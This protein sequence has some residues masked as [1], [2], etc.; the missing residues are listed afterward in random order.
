LAAAARAAG[1]EVGW[2]S[3]G[4]S[5]RWVGEMEEIAA[6]LESAGVTGGFHRA[7]VEVYGRLTGFKNDSTVGGDEVL[8]ALLA[9]LD[10]Q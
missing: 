7:A 8:D 5:W 1:A 4:R 6:A 10:W 2:A 9:P 3:A